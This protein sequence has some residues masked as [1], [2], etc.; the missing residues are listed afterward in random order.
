MSKEYKSHKRYTNSTFYSK[1]DYVLLKSWEEIEETYP[2]EVFN[3]DEE[4]SEYEIYIKENGV[5]IYED[6][7]EFLGQMVQ[8]TDVSHVTGLNERYSI[9][10]TK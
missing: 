2:S 6:T 9:N 10:E 4:V 5:Y 3:L 8:L 1:N 7:K